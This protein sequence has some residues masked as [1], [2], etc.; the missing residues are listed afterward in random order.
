MQRVLTGGA[1]LLVGAFLLTG[2]GWI[3]GNEVKVV[4]PA[5]FIAPDTDKVAVF[6]PGGKTLADVAYGV[7][8]ADIR[9]QCERADHG[10][11]VKTKI[12]FHVVSNDRSLRTGAFQYFV[13][14]VDG[15]QNILT[16]NTY[17]VPFEFDSRMRD[18][19]RKDELLENLPL[20]NAGTGGNYAIV[21]GLQLTEAQLNFNRAAQH[22]PGVAMAP[23]V[24]V[25]VPPK[26]SG[27]TP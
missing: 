9:S 21:V 8:I 25:A 15:E 24:K 26:G 16:K 2:C 5:S 13:S 11:T 12:A 18:L 19:D 7:Q 14:V 17:T 27:S 6:K 1:L 4:C 23:T 3:G 20:R 22:S 10:L